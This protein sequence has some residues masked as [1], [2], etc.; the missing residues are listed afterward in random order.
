[1]TGLHTGAA[2]RVDRIACLI[3][4]IEEAATDV[5]GASLPPEWQRVGMK[6]IVKAAA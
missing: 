5:I 6:P 1:L 3:Q 4:Q 2:R